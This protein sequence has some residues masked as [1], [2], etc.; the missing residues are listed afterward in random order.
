MKILFAGGGTAG[1]INPAIAIAKK[2]KGDYKNIQIKFIGTKNGLEK[3]LVPSSGFDIEF[4]NIDGFK[5]KLTLKNASSLLKLPIAIMQAIK[6]LKSFKPDVVVG[7]GGY[8]SGPVVFGAYLLNIKTVIHEQNVI[9]G[10]TSKILSKFATKIAISFG[11]S[12]KYFKAKKRLVTTG[13]PLRDE[14]FSTS[15]KAAR[16]K[17]D[18]KNEFLVLCFAGS[19]GAVTIYKTMVDYINLSKENKNLMLIFATGDL[20]YEDVLEELLKLN[21]DL[22]NY[23]NIKVLKYI[24]NMAEVINAADLVI[25]RSGAITISELIALSKPSILI[26]SPNVTN[27]HQYHNAKVLERYRAAKVIDENMLKGE[28]LYNEV[29]NLFENKEILYDMAKHSGNI[30]TK[31]SNKKLCELIINIINEK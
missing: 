18:I 10:V 9:P 20:Y 16:E 13:N 8:V 5:R 14:L 31:N 2:L 1:H 26:P 27:N 7:T 4:I 17:L 6:I 22:S 25:A 24:F 21:I 29:L 28:V 12:K 15:Y 3:T 30:G 11:D 19:L 23:P